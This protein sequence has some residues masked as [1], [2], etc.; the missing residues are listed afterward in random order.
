[1][2]NKVTI[3]ITE[4][5]WETKVNLDEKQY[6]EKH[7]RTSFGSSGVFGNFEDEEN[8]P[9]GLYDALLDGCP[10]DIMRELGNI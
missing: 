4:F 10:Y 3:E 9:D 5:G 6:I 2:E 7:E 1:M 8:L